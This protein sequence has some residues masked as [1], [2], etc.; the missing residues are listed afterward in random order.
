MRRLRR[1]PRRGRGARGGGSN[2]RELARRV[3][4]RARHPRHAWIMVPAGEITEST[5]Q[6]PRSAPDQATRS[7]TA[8]TPTTGTTS[9]GLPSS[10]QRGIRYVDCG[11]SGGV[12][13]LDRGFCLMVGGRD[14]AF[15]ELEPIFAS[16]APGIAAAERTP[17]RERRA[18]AGGARL[19][20]LRARGGR[21]LRED[22]AQRDR[23]RD[24]GRPRGG[25]E[26]PSRCRRRPPPAG[27]GRRDGAARPSRVLSYTLD[28]PAI[29]EVWRR[30]Q[31]RRIV[32]ARPDCRGAPGVARPRRTSPGAYPTRARAAG[33]RS[34]RSR[35]ACPPTCSP[36]RSTHA[37]T[38]ARRGRL[39]EPDTL[40]DAQAVRR[41]PGEAGRRA[42]DRRGR[43]GAWTRACRASATASGREL[44][45]IRRGQHASRLRRDRP[46][47][48]ST[49][50]G[51]PAFGTPSHAPAPMFVT[52]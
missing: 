18:G 13:G 42:D 44:A 30:G 51:P 22:G 38:R 10:P 26:H 7:S 23:V 16:L 17:G 48:T 40:G 19:S 9:A 32:A 11:T 45:E 43:R 47:S 41:P 37:S 36:R 29:A 5:V 12:F 2:R 39:R 46:A 52:R 31:R 4:R 6:R 27:R 8:A 14:D 33:R 49:S 34:R 20:P 1:Q 21:A 35:R 3:R 28:L 24:D 25:I 15:A 50:R